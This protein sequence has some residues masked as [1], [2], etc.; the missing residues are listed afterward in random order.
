MSFNISYSHEMNLYSAW[1][2]LCA[3]TANHN[4]YVEYFSTKYEYCTL[5][6]SWALHRVVGEF[7]LV[8]KMNR[9]TI[10]LKAFT[11]SS[12]PIFNVLPSIANPNTL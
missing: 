4:S 3:K 7:H 12:I 8:S 9:H 1:S 10:N 2:H 11:I 5:I 6:L